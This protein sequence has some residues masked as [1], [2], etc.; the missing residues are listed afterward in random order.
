MSMRQEMR[1]E[2]GILKVDARGEFS[3]EE[4][5]RAFLELLAAVVHYQAEK[6]LLDGRNIKGNP[7]HIERFYYGYFAA[8]ETIS[9]TTKYRLHQQPQFAYVL[10][11]PLRDRERY[12]EKVAVN[13]GMNIKVFETLEEASKWLGAT[14][15]NKPE[16]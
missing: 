13:R 10:H 15:G 3:L 14:T 1:F 11:E 12:G 2:S 4:A 6:I 8:A 16:T 5:K 9:F 7:A